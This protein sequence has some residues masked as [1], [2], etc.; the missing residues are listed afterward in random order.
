MSGSSPSAVEETS[1][2][3][4]PPANADVS[5][6][7]CSEVVIRIVQ[8]GNGRPRDGW[9]RQRKTERETHTYA[10]QS[11]F[12]T[13]PIRRRNL[14]IY[15]DDG[16]QA[17]RGSVH[18]SVVLARSLVE[19]RVLSRR[20]ETELL[21]HEDAQDDIIFPFPRT[22]LEIECTHHLLQL[23]DGEPAQLRLGEDT[24]AHKVR[25][26]GGAGRSSR[27]CSSGGGGSGSCCC[28]TCCSSYACTVCNHT[29]HCR[30]A[31]ST[32]S[33]TFP[34]PFAARTCLGRWAL[35]PV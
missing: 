4:V 35:S 29:V 25:R 24:R 26:R 17:T 34:A 14:H 31:R 18:A 21:F 9:M 30:R 3:I 28:C 5:V 27:T 12:H 33:S 2:T 11:F 16:R 8:M 6:H 7:V 13:L 32:H 20:V 15:I 10:Q 1:D 22:D 23:I 19:M